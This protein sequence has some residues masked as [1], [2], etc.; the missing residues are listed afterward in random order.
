MQELIQHLVN[1][2]AVEL[3]RT[4][5]T[6]EMRALPS[7][8]S[9]AE[10]ALSGAQAKA[11]EA[12]AALM[13]EEQLRTRLER[14]ITDHRQKAARFRTQIDSVTTPAQAAAIEHEIQF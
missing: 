3:E 9:Q 5:L 14:E 7:E 2:Q 6:Q 12:S 4:R 10:T 1:L 11:A 13:R 8:L